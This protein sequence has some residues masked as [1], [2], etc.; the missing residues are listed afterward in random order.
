MGAAAAWL[1]DT[2]CPATVN[3]A[4]R[5]VVAVLGATVYDSVPAPEPA[6]PAV[7]VIQLAGFD[8]DHAQP[9]EVETDTEPLPPPETNDCEVGVTVYPQLAGAA[10]LTVTDCPAIVSVAVREAVVPLADAVIVTVPLPEP[11]APP[12]M[13]AHAAPLLA[14]QLHPACAVTVTVSVPPAAAAL[15][16]VGDTAYAHAWPAWVTVT[17]WPAI[18]KVPVR[19]DV[20]AL[21]AAAI[22]TVPPPLPLAPAVTLS[23]LALD[24]VVHVHPVP[25]VTLSLPVHA[26]AVSDQLSGLTAYVQGTANMNVF[27]A[28]LV[29]EPPGP[30]ATTRDSY[31][32]PGD[33]SVTVER[34]TWTRPSPA[35]AGLPS[36][37]I[38]N[39]EPAPWR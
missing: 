11:L 30:T 16:L 19:E 12:V 9:A 25:A 6:A 17:V 8:E 4:D 2:G 28:V 18:V 27:D 31:T 21:A 3:V 37:E 10:W 14:V 33:G 13:A 34:F 24:I 39:G 20:P 7:M 5:D 35:G 26:A 32:M 22:D 1:M 36:D 29:P 38:W 23:Q 15:R